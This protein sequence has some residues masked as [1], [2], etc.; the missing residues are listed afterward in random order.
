[1]EVAKSS[2]LKGAAL[3][4]AMLASG[5]SHAD[6]F[7]DGKV[8]ATGG[9]SMIDGAGG[10]GITPWATITGY[11]TDQGING[12]VHYTYAPLANYTLH[13]LGVAVGFWD[14]FELSYTTSSLTTGSTF[15]TVGLVVDTVN[16]LTQ[17]LGVPVDTGIDPWNTTIDME[18]IGAKLRVWGDAV[19]DSDSFMPQIAIGGFYKTNKNEEL[20]TTLGADTAKD[21]EAYIS[22]TKILFPINT[23]INITARYTAANQTGLTGFGGPDG[24]DKEFRPEVSLAYLLRKDTVIGVEWAQHG[25]NQ[26]GQSIQVSGLSLT[27]VTGILGDLGLGGVENTLEQ[28]ESDWFDAF[29]AFFPSKNLSITMAYAMLGNI[30]LTPDQHGFYMSLQAS[31]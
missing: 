17:E 2:K 28:Q 27:S 15:N 25:D 8:L 5:I 13:S 24:S 9:V 1:M 10:G 21:W 29:V 16:D 4:V 7:D 18:I 22:A 30:T 26:S 14:R 23:L 19:Y 6:W 3:V 12:N 11:G 20:L 31:F